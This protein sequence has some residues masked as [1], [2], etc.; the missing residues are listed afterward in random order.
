MPLNVPFPFAARNGTA[1]AKNP[2]RTAQ[3]FR[4]VLDQAAD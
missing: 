3:A 4:P 1:D 2:R